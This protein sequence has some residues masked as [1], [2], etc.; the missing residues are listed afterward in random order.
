MANGER[1]AMQLDALAGT[2]PGGCS[3]DES[4][5]LKDGD[6]G[7][8]AQSLGVWREPRGA[9]LLL[10]SLAAAAATSLQACGSGTG[11]GS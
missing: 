1:M 6:G 3:D 9:T 7:R 8:L 4:E 5:T 11:P 10:W 2:A